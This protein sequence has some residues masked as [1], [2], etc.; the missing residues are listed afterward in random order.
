MAKDYMQ[1]RNNLINNYTPRHYDMSVFL[2][3]LIQID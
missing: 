2:D 3:S 1:K